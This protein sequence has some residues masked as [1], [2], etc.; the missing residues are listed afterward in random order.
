MPTPADI[1]EAAALAA[2]EPAS[3]SV[4][5]ETTVGLDPL[6]ALDVADRLAAR[7]AS[8]QRQSGWRGVII[9]RGRTQGAGS[10]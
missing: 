8:R 3:S 6:K 10:S 5:G 2:T 9:A 7:E 1:E 4:D